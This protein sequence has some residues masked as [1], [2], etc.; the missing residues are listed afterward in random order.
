MFAGQQGA[1]V[2]KMVLDTICFGT[3]SRDHQTYTPGI[4][5]PFVFCFT[6]FWFL[7]AP[8]PSISLLSCHPVDAKGS[9]VSF[10]GYL[11]RQDP[12]TT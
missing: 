7:R 3:E 9:A 12:E 2:G 8:Q 5:D 10:E 4:D 11:D 1:G 6:L